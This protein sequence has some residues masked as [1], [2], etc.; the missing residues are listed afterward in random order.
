[1]TGAVVSS[2]VMA[3]TPTA[4]AAPARA[5]LARGRSGRLDCVRALAPGAV[6]VVD[7]VVMLVL[8]R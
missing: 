2:V 4:R 3:T 8:L 6:A 5:R 1:L 7:E